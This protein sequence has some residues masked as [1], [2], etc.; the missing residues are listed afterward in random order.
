MSGNHNPFWISCTQNGKNSLEQ[1]VLTV[2]NSTN[3][4]DKKDKKGTASETLFST[5]DQ[6]TMLHPIVRGRINPHLA[7][8]KHVNAPKVAD[9]IQIMEK[10]S[11]KKSLCDKE[12]DIRCC[13]ATS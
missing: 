2:Q 10:N 13:I 5:M 12:E 3:V 9:E 6:F 8:C 7:Y 11:Q 4:L 1:Y